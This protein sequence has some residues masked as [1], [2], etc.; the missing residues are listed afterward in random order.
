[1]SQRQYNQL[2]TGPEFLLSVRYAQILN[3]VGRRMPTRSQ[4]FAVVS[5]AGWVSSPASSCVADLCD[6]TVLIGAAVTGTHCGRQLPHGVLGRQVPVLPLLRH[7][8][9]GKARGSLV[10]VGAAAV[11]HRLMD[12]CGVAIPCGPH[13]STTRSWAGACHRCCRTRSC[14]TWRSRCGCTATPTSLSHPSSLSRQRYVPRV[15][16]RRA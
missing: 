7:A 15:L 12:L 13:C 16:H 1:M 10:L 3:A 11:S 14:C 8:A 6:T 5:L 2:H 9:A 4:G